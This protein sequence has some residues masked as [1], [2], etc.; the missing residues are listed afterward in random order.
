MAE[1][2]GD[3]AATLSELER[4]LK[5]LERELES[6]GHGGEVDVEPAQATGA[7]ADGEPPP[8]AGHPTGASPP[9]GPAGPQGFPPP[10]PFHGHDT[11]GQVAG[12]PAFPPPPPGAFGP[13]S[14]EGF[15]PSPHHAHDV[16][17][18]PP[19]GPAPFSMPLPTGHVPPGSTPVRPPWPPANDGA[20]VAEWQG[21]QG[22]PPPSQPHH[23]QPAPAAG[24]SALREHLAEL[25]RVRAQ[26]VDVADRL[27]SELS[28][29]VGELEGGGEP[30]LEGHVVVEVGRFADVATLGA[31][32]QALQRIPGVRDVYVRALDQGEA[33]I[34][35]ELDRPLRLASELGAVAPAA[36]RVVAAGG[37]R[38]HLALT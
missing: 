22:P 7:P 4:K 9:P 31:F 34:D 26:L 3:I 8:G 17:A 33:S 30:V 27:V 32:E 1:A 18:P 29:A 25:E 23:Q 35:V 19:P 20:F 21:G 36:F 12:H 14:T 13:I 28:R 11:G 38:L 37:G 2:H 10:P 6:V 15:A 24:S 16:L 5:K